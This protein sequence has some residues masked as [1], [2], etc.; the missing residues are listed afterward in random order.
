MRT[1]SINSNTSTDVS[2][3]RSIDF[4]DII[5]CWIS[6]SIPSPYILV[7]INRDISV[8]LIITDRSRLSRKSVSS[9]HD[10]PV[11]IQPQSVVRIFIFLCASNNVQIATDDGLINI[12]LCTTDFA[13][14]ARTNI[15]KNIAFHLAP[16][17]TF[18]CWRCSSIRIVIN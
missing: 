3:N 11:I 9:S 13:R 15:Q 10:W 16:I 2:A 12:F 1:M 14:S 4:R 8:N 6:T 5:R 18:D 17:S 7:S